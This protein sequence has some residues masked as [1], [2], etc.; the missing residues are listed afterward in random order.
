M[1][2][3][4][5]LFHSKLDKLKASLRLTGSDPNGDVQNVIEDCVR[6]FK[7]WFT[8]RAG[9]AL[10]TTLQEVVETDDPTT[11]LETRRLAAKVLEVKWVWCECL[12]R[13]QSLFADASGAAFQE[14]NDQGVWRQLGALDQRQLLRT[15]AR[16]IEDL[17]VFVSGCL[18]IGEGEEIQ[19]FDGTTVGTE[20]FFPAGT[21]FPHLGKFLGNFLV[22]SI[23]FDEVSTST[24][25]EGGL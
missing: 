22:P 6:G 5:P 19:I 2:Q 14:F 1:A 20:S 17:Y 3:I 24:P 12:K 15:C 13:L 21:A 4:R 10:I 18:G 16:E 25:L 8:R 7:V 9:F 11:E 23:R